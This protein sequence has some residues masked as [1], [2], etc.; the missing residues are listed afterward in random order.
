MVLLV[1]C[2]SIITPVFSAEKWPNLICSGWDEVFVISGE[3]PTKKLWSWRAVDSPELPSRLHR[4]FRTTDECKPYKED[5]LLITSSAS[6]VALLRR[7]DK[8]CLFYATA[9]NAHSAC[10]L[11]GNRVAVAAS[12]GGDQLMI[13]D[14]RQ[15]GS[16][17]LATIPLKGAHG[18]HWDSGTRILWALGN[19][20]LLKC[21]LAGE[22]GETK[23]TVAKRWKLPTYGGHDLSALP[24]N[25]GLFITSNSH[26]YRFLFASETFKPD[27]LLGPE[28]IVKSV[29]QFEA[30]AP[31]VYHQAKRPNWWSDTIRFGGSDKVIR[32]PGERLYKVRW[33]RPA[34]TP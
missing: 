29:D 19:G 11:P 21:R 34:E 4:A 18:A 3:A 5:L 17:A 2:W 31:I 6:G 15:P 26:V 13:F 33:D 20:E 7:S 14:R 32:L 30:N 16:D 12:N 27:P 10:L 8:S 25:T 22:D 24:G 28:A 23:L 9:R 1:A